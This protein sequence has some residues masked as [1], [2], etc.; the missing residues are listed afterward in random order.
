MVQYWCGD[1]VVHEDDV[2]P[3]GRVFKPGQDLVLNRIR[4]IVL[5]VDV[6]NVWMR[7]ALESEQPARTI[8]KSCLI[9]ALAKIEEGDD[10]VGFPF[11]TICMEPLAS[12][13]RKKSSYS[14]FAKLCPMFT[15][16]EKIFSNWTVV[17]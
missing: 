8:E 7:P 3:D 10:N 12:K 1:E 5:S 4:H 13:L 14:D 16:N 15:L 11:G 6:D 17:E 2:F 9:C